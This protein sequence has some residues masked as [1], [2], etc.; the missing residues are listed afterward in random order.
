MGHAVFQAA[1]ILD[2]DIPDVLGIAPGKEIHGHTGEFCQQGLAQLALRGISQLMG[3]REGKGDQRIAGY[4]GSHE[5][6]AIARQRLGAGGRGRVQHDCYGPINDQIH[7]QRGH[8]HQAARHQGGEGPA[9]GD[10]PDE[11]K[12]AAHRALSAPPLACGHSTP[13]PAITPMRHRAIRPQYSFR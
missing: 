5:Q 3:Q 9:F 2:H 6:N 11:R 1:D 13:S 12:T 7:G 10:G 4:D 8:R